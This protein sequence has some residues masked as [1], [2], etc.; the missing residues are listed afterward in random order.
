MPITTINETLF[1]QQIT[2]IQNDIYT[3][4]TRATLTLA[5]AVIGVL[6]TVI[7]SIISARASRKTARLTGEIQKI[8][9]ADRTKHEKQ[10]EY[11]KAQMTLVNAAVDVMWR[12]IFNKLV[13]CDRR[14][15]AASK[16]NFFC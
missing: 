9:S 2:L 16:N 5:V 3:A 11:F 14:T 13:L 4:Q 7:A 12:L 6:G 8:I 1:Q 10:W 15:D